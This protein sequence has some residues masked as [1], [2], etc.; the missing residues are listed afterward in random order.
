MPGEAKNRDVKARFGW[1]FAPDAHAHGGGG[2][3]I[4]L[5]EVRPKSFQLPFRILRVFSFLPAV[6]PLR[7]T[8]APV[9]AHAFAER[10][11]IS[12]TRWKI[13]VI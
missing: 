7:L 12:G 8:A 4:R 10:D 9:H 1:R 6:A 2:E 11:W 5:V 13:T 3:T